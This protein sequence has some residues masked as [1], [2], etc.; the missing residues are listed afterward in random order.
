MLKRI[1]K[2][3][4]KEIKIDSKSNFT[5]EV[6]HSFIVF[7]NFINEYP[8]Q[9]LNIYKILQESMIKMLIT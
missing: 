7:I 3:F 8:D 4:D 2:I 5:W 1:K 6:K 9:Q